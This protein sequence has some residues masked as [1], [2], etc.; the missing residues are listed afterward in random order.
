[1]AS[2][3]TAKRQTNKPAKPYKEF[4]LFPHAT[5]RWAKKIRGKL[6]Y[7]GPWDD[8]DAALAKYLEQKDDLHAGRKPRPKTEGLTVKELANRFLNGKRDRLHTGEITER[9][10]QDYFTTCSIIVDAFG[11]SRAVVDLDSDDFEKLRRSLAKTR[12]PVAIGNEVNR[13]RGVFKYGYEAG[14]IE[15]PVRFGPNFKRPTRKTL[16][17]HRQKKQ[18]TNGKRMFPADELRKIIDA[19]SQPMRAMILLGINCGFGQSDISNMPSSAVD[20]ESGWIDYPRPKTAVERRCWLWPE[21]VD[22]LRD[23]MQNRPDAK[24]DADTGLAF[25]TKYGKRWVKLNKNNT[26]DDAIGKEF[27]KLLKS[28]DLKRPGVS[29][30]ALRHTFETI[31]GESRD[32]VAVNAVM[33]HVDSTMAGLYREHI[34]DDRLRAVAEAVRV[35]LFGS[36]GSDGE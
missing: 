33:G 4:P 10:F 13:I 12:G 14:L 6:H 36:E 31:A 2:Q 22:A 16:R 29:F 8:P 30:Y 9:T 7:F 1:M 19:A 15:R 11:K 17:K 28:L 24:D 5:K 27:T 35:W 20:L 21:T 25:V 26:P 3:S 23:A 18:A 32:Q 34:S